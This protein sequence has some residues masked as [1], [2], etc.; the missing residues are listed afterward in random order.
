M[1]MRFTHSAIAMLVIASA[2]TAQDVVSIALR[3][4]ATV[5]KRV[6]RIGD[7]ADVE[8]GPEALRQ[9]IADLDLDELPPAGQT[10]TCPRTQIAFR[11]RLAGVPAQLFRVSGAMEA[12]I[13]P[14]R[15]L[16]E[17]GRV[18]A[19]A[20]AALRRRLPESQEELHVQLSQPI[21][22]ALPAIADDEAVEIDAEL[23]RGTP[24][25]GRMQMSVTVRVNG[26]RRLA[27]W[28]FLEV[29]AIREIA[30]CRQRV[31]RGEVVGEGAVSR[32][33]RPV[34]A[35]DT[36]ARPENVI[37]RKA[38]KPL[39]P[40]QVLSANDVENTPVTLVKSGQ[41]LRL[42]VRLG[43]MDVVAMGEALQGGGAGDLIR[44]RNVESKKILTGRVTGPRT[45]E[46]DAG[47]P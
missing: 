14:R 37:G 6:V 16:L 20:I 7:V 43:A 30:V 13:V 29:Q 15:K 27:V 3:D 19:A 33:R 18:E 24:G 4:R 31:E 40:G 9:R 26:E 45:V 32:E 38:R 12:V 22:A 46:V 41:P 21:S 1:P 44:V 25:V 42:I 36:A 23:H 11:L 34:T 8:G 17:P 28:V 10:R 35:Q 39:A 5:S 2:A 47:S